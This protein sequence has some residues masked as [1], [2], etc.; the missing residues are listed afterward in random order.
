MQPRRRYNA[1]GTIAWIT[2]TTEQWT[3]D[4]AGYTDTDPKTGRR[5]ASVW[6]EASGRTRMVPVAIDDM[7]FELTAAVDE[8]VDQ[9]HDIAGIAA[10]LEQTIER[11]DSWVSAGRPRGRAR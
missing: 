2:L 6:C 11:Y 5:R 1:D 9:E 7:T 4:F 8:L 10:A 3:V